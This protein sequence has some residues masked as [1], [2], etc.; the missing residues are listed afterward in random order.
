MKFLM[1]L[2][3]KFS[4]RLHHW[5]MNRLGEQLNSKQNGQS[6]SNIMLFKTESQ[7]KENG[8]NT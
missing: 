6:N 7:V 5:F 8:I 1:S 3:Q 2:A 4:H